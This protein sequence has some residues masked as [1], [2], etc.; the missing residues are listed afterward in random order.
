MTY[1]L[2]FGSTVAVHAQLFRVVREKDWQSGRVRY[3]SSK[4]YGHG[5]EKH[6]GTADWPEGESGS[7]VRMVRVPFD[8]PVEGVVIGNTWRLEGRRTPRVSYGS[9]W[10][11]EPVEANDGSL[12]DQRRV[13]VVQVA[14][15]VGPRRRA[16]IVTAAPADITTELRLA[17]K[18]GGTLTLPAML[19]VA[20]RVSPAGWAIG[21]ELRDAFETV[22]APILNEP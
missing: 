7:F 16:Q 8:D 14:L 5:F 21:A 6:V 12:E 9:S 19:V 4:G 11:G 13:E 3:F 17:L 15:K 22:T 20:R 1:P 18:G 2:P 10:G